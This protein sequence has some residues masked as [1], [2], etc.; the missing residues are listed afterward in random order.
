MIG[1]GGARFEP[2]LKLGNAADHPVP[3]AHQFGGDTGRH[4]RYSGP[5]A[6]DVTHFCF[7]LAI[8]PKFRPI[9]GHRCLVVYQSSL[10]L[11]VQCGGCNSLSNGENWEKRAAIYR[12]SGLPVNGS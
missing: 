3:V 9:L 2:W 8:G 7:S 11:D 5:V 10:G 1:V 6:E 12:S 4:L